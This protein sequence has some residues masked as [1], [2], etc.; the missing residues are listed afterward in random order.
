MTQRLFIMRHGETDWSRSGQ[1]TGRTDLPLTQRGEEEARQLGTRIRDV[2]FSQ[3][4]TSP[5]QRAQK[6]CEIAG[7][8][9]SARSDPNLIEWDN[10]QY[11]GLTTAQILEAHPGWDL[12]RD[13]CPGGELPAEVCQRASQFIQ[14][15]RDMPGNIA[16]FTHGH[17]ARALATQW[18]GIP[19]KHGSNFVLGTAA[20]SILAYQHNPPFLPIIELWNSQSK[21]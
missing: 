12:Y 5:L 17:F 2:T 14:A 10:G 16:L 18:I 8:A 20:L 13:G 15:T 1:H 6:T 7:L 11:E 21:L 3:V 9:G 4:F 19:V